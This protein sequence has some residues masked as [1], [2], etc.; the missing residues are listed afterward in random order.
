MHG[1]PAYMAPEAIDGSAEVGAPA[2]VYALGCVA[3]YLL[4]GAPVFEG[5]T[6]V[7]VAAKHLHEAPT[8]PGARVP[9][10]IPPELDALVMA[11]LAKRPDERPADCR[12]LARELRRIARESTPAWG[13]E[14]A[15]LWWEA[16]LPDMAELSSAA[17]SLR[18]P[19]A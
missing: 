4:V 1:T 12:A 2:D 5:T 15:Q 7:A 18:A 3:Y 10:P 14:A 11:C 16:N 9:E 13:P 8:S 6:A 17:A 19:P